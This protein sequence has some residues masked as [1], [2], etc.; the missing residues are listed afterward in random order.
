MVGAARN[1]GAADEHLATC[2]TPAITI[3]LTVITAVMH[4]IDDRREDQAEP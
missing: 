4:A 1:G 3:P 2:V